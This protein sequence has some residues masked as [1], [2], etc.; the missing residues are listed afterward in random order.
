MKEGRGKGVL[1]GC[2]GRDKGSD[3]FCISPLFKGILQYSRGRMKK[4]AIISQQAP[5]NEN[6]VTIKGSNC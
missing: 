2:L 1:R 6:S 3:F 5:L 4:V